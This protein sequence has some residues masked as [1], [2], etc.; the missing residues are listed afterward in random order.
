MTSFGSIGRRERLCNSLSSAHIPPATAHISAKWLAFIS[1]KNNLAFVVMSLLVHQPP[2]AFIRIQHVRSHPFWNRLVF[3]IGATSFLLGYD[4]I[5]VPAKPVPLRIFG[6]Q[7]NL[8]FAF[9]S[10]ATQLLC[11]DGDWQERVSCRIKLIE[12]VKYKKCARGQI[13]ECFSRIT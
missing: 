7:P 11:I 12:H 2:N 3:G 5:R 4:I 1:R 13:K 9:V 8:D 6:F 10:V